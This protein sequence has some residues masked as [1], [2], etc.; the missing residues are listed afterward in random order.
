ME[1]LKTLA[2]EGKLTDLVAKAKERSVQMKKI[3]DEKK[4]ALGS[5]ES[6]TSEPKK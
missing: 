5:P 1:I 4:K 6:G 2:Q 3:K